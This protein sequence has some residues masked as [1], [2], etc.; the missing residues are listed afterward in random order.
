MAA[1]RNAQGG[2]NAANG[3]GSEPNAFNPGQ[4]G[5]PIQA[6]GISAI[7]SACGALASS[8]QTRATSNSPLTIFSVKGT[9]RS[10]WTSTRTRGCA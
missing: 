10:T 8:P 1:D 6:T 2:E 7:R 5:R 9:L 3:S 4:S